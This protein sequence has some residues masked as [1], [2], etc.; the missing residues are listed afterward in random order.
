M[1]DPVRD[2]AEA[3]EKFTMHTAAVGAWLGAL[4]S[5]F[6]IA[7]DG[8][9]LDVQTACTKIMDRAQQYRALATAARALLEAHCKTFREK[10]APQKFGMNYGP[11]VELK[12]ALDRLPPEQPTQE[13]AAP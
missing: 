13:K 12:D 7:M 9:T 6:G 1:M 3:R 2:L 10:P 11:L 8:E 5:E 4:S